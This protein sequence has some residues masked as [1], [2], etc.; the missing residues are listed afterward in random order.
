MR[1][2]EIV[3]HGRWAELILNRP[4]RR[5]AINGPLGLALADGLR[6][7]NSDPQIQ[8]VLLR[9]ADGAFCS[10]LD[11]KE[12]NADPPPEWLVRF[13]DI[14]RATHKAL[15]QSKKPLVV[16]LERFA[17]NGGAAL[18][19]AGDLMF[20]GRESFLQVGEVRQGMA[21]PYNMAWLRLRHSAAITAR[22]AL[23]GH[24]FYGRELVEM[25]VAYAAP[26]EGSVVAE[27]IALVEELVDYPDQAL[28]RIKTTLRAYDD[29]NADAWFDRATQA[30]ER[31]G[32]P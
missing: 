23:T 27:A 19:L 22:L 28:E 14:W 3:V 26:K 15:F 20:V 29:E 24:R 18:A 16:A 4:E 12:F 11:L 5:N 10:G 7:I 30:T 8:V 32:S 1:E 2:V 9:G 6:T 13:G 17:I 25:G 31:T 21:A